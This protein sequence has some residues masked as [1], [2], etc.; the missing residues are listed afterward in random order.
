[1]PNL[2]VD[3]K[4]QFTVPHIE[5]GPIAR[6]LKENAKEIGDH[7]DSKIIWRVNH[8]RFDTEMRYT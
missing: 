8:E 2:Q 4:E 1:M 3:E 5:L 7:S 6:L